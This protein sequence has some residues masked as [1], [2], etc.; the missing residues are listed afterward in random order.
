MLL[1]MAGLGARLAFLHLGPKEDIQDRVFRTRLSE[2]TI[3]AERGRIL[4]RNQNILA[5]DL[6]VKDVWVCPKTILENGHAHFVTH[7]LARLLQL[8]PAF[9]YDRVNRPGRQFEYVKR[10]VPRDVAD[11]I[12]RMQ[13]TG[14]HFDGVTARHYPQG[15]LMSHVVGFSNFDGIGSAGVEQGMN[16]YLRGRPGL[17]VS[18]RDGRRSEIYNR[19]RLVIEPKRGADVY[20]TLDQNLQFMVEESLDRALDAYNAQSAWAI[21]QHVQ[22]GEILAMAS[23]P[24]YDLNAFRFT[25]EETRRNRAIG[26][27]FEPGSTFKALVIAA[28][29]DAGAV[30]VE[31]TFDCEQGVWHYGGR[32]LRDYR[33]HGVLDVYGILQKS[34]NIGAAKIALE[35]GN[36]RLEEYLRDFG[37]GSTVGI[38]LPG[39]EPGILA[40]RSSWS[41]ISATRIAMGHEV[42]VTALQLLNA[43]NA[44]AN[45]GFLM[46]PYVVRQVMDS[47]GRV[48]FQ[49]EPQVLARPVREDTAR[50]M[51]RIMSRVTEEGGTGRQAAL[52]GYRVAGKTGTAQKPVP[53]GYSDRANIASFVGF[54]P[55][56]HP[57]FSMIIVLDEPQPLR[58]GG[59][60]AAPVFKE[61]ADQAVRYLGIAPDVSVADAQRGASSHGR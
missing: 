1:V 43:V 46:R 49:N 29:L 17:R 31:H 2:Q 56:D 6:P 26:Y 55:A 42:A 23:R 51:R 37:I 38:D 4:D 52:E 9:V 57:E 32:P 12:A 8:D 48:V 36:Q 30:R 35:L 19:R 5:L 10:F 11:Q 16:A 34:S 40:S 15:A 21:I 3:L 50:L 13:L 20:L 47:Q 7:Q 60:T 27:N 14:V 61:I 28:A 53:G 54:L 39:E 59:A 44:I 45:D 18:E 24:T 41:Q 22:T 33:P 25:A 58:T